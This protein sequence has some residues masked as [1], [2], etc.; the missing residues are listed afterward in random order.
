ML[1]TGAKKKLVPCLEEAL[2]IEVNL[3]SE[4]LIDAERLFN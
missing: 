2:R 1:R 3:Q 4:G